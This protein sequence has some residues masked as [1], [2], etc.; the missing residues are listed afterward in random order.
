MMDIPRGWKLILE[1]E[2]GCFF[3]ALKS[4]HNI[5]VE[6]FLTCGYEASITR[7]SGLVL[8]AHHHFLVQLS[9]VVRQA[10]ALPVA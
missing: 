4:N 5:F 6:M 2:S 3:S 1:R 8:P 7:T 9:I 10:Y